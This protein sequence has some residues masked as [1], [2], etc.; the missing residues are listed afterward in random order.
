MPMA[1]STA[2]AP[3]DSCPSGSSILYWPNGAPLPAR[4]ATAASWSAVGAGRARPHCVDE[5]R[6][7]SSAVLAKSQLELSVQPR[8]MKAVGAAGP[9]QAWGRPQPSW[10]EIKC[11]PTMGGHDGWHRSAA[12]NSLS[13]CG[14]QVGQ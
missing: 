4:P 6:P 2:A 7:A 11:K 3:S 9:S 13:L 12:H 10:C 5:L 14:A 8:Y 1:S